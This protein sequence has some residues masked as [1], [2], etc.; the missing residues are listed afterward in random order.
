MYCNAQIPPY[1]PQNGLVGWWPFNATAVD[2]SA[3][4]NDGTVN[5]A[6]LTT[7]RFGLVGSAYEFDGVNDNITFPNAI[8]FGANSFTI[9]LYCYIKEWGSQDVKYIFGSPFTG[10]NDRGFRLSTDPQNGNG[11][12][13]GAIGD[14][15]GNVSYVNSQQLIQLARWYYLTIVF[16]RDAS[17]FTLYIDGVPAQTVNVAA[18]FANTDLGIA[19]TVGSFRFSA[20]WI[21]QFF[22]GKIDDIAVWNRALT[23]QEVALTYNACDFMVVTQPSGQ[24]VSSGSSAT[25]SV[26]TTEPNSI[27]YRWQKKVG[28]QFVDLNDPSLFTNAW[29]S[30]VTI[31][32]V[33]DQ[34]AGTYRCMLTFDDCTIYSDEVSVTLSSPPAPTSTACLANSASP[35]PGSFPTAA[36]GGYM[37]LGNHGAPTQF[38][39]SMWVKPELTSHAIT[40]LLDCSHGSNR[41]WVIQSL[42]YGANWV[43]L[44]TTFAL[45]AGEW[46]HLLCTFNNGVSKVYINGSLVAQGSWSIVWSGTQNLYLGNW[47]EGGRRFKGQVDE[48][49]I[50]RN[51]LYTDEFVPLEIIDN[52]DV[53]ANSLGLWHFDEGSGA[54]TANTV[55]S[56]SIAVNNWTWTSRSLTGCDAIIST[57]P[58]GGQVGQGQSK[59]LSV[60]VRSNSTVAY[61]WQRDGGAGFANVSNNSAFTGST[62]TVLTL[63][64]FTALEAGTYRCQVSSSGCVQ[65]SES[66]VLSLIPPTQ[67]YGWSKILDSAQVQLADIYFN[68]TAFDQV[69]N[70]VYGVNTLTN[71]MTVKIIDFD[72]LTVETFQVTR[73]IARIDQYTLDRAGGRLVATRAGADNVYALNL[74]T[75]TW[76]QIGNG[77]TDDNSY[78]AVMYWNKAL[79]AVEYFAGYGYTTAKNWVKR[80]S[81][82]GWSTVFANQSNC[83]PT[84][85]PGCYASLGHPDS[86]V[87][88]FSGGQGN[89]SG[90]QYESSCSGGA[91]WAS[92]LGKWCWLK[93]CYRFDISTTSFTQVRPFSDATYVGEGPVAYDYH[94]RKMYQFPQHIPPTTYPGSFTYFDTTHVYANDVDGS[95]GYS[96]LQVTGQLPPALSGGAAFYDGANRR[97]VLVRSDG[98]WALQTGACPTVFT[99]Q[100]QS[101]TVIEGQSTSLSVAVVASSGVTYQWQQNTGSGFVN[102]TNSG[103]FTGVT[104]STLSINAAVAQMQGTYR[105]QAT[106]SGCGAYSSSATLT[107]TPSTS[108]PI[109]VPQD[110]LVAWWPF[111][112]NAEDES[113]YSNNG[114]VTGARLTTDRFGSSNKAYD[115]NGTSDFIEVPSSNELQVTTSYTISVWFKADVLSASASPNQRSIV[116]KIVNGDWYGGYEV[117]VIEGT[118]VRQSGNIGGTNIDARA[119]ASLQNSTWYH[120]AFTYDGAKIRTYLNGVKADSGNITGALGSGTTPLRFGRRGGAGNYNNWFDGTIDD[121][122]IWNRALTDAEVLALYSS[123][124]AAITTQPTSKAARDGQQVSLTVGLNNTSGAIYQW[125]RKDGSS[126]VNIVSDAR[127]FGANTSKLTIE[128][129][130]ASKSG[131]YRCIVTAGGC[132]LTSNEATLTV[133]CNCGSN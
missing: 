27:I 53:P 116:S 97:V 125:Q 12:L 5:G 44:G 81:G 112:G 3:G 66:V 67:Q 122:A 20:N 57:Q 2:E 88:Y 16:D 19:P 73:P 115:F 72:D 10:T 31:N 4:T 94:E 70:R 76:T 62:T 118:D 40:V 63:A 99:S 120:A 50:T 90:N 17:T 127:Y 111:N 71:P 30:T 133:N 117:R 78:G 54:T 35:N 102:L 28:N 96:R 61:Q 108:I 131:P 100:P 8:N 80:N 41:N 95:Q 26:V 29:T 60:T 91:A 86:N 23:A 59:T 68:T 18:N 74:S 82:G 121:A 64:A 38:S 49:L 128:S 119:S 45:Q 105:C 126:W 89:C 55:S 103:G 56:S 22:N 39:V 77:T 110:G 79:N 123:C 32:T 7:D 85:R 48:L 13:Q 65:Y 21:A 132:T 92:D 6:T 129:A 114:V 130:Q 42:D 37:A 109:Y 58:V 51:V 83:Q 113:S 1:I 107:V 25:L 43:F 84:K 14:G 124:N 15:T 9:G 11:S 36:N 93:D 69:N 34:T 98:V 106:E 104:S 87:I 47:P 101:T 52:D 75:K 33:N 46:Q 24:S